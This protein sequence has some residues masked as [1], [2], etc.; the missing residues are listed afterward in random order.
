MAKMAYDLSPQEQ[1]AAI[2]LHKQNAFIDFGD[3]QMFCRPE[4]KKNINLAVLA[5]G[6]DYFQVMGVMGSTNV[7]WPPAL[8]EVFR[9]FSV[10]LASI[11]V[12]AP[13]CL[14]PSFTFATQFY[15]TQL[16]PLAAGGQLLAIHVGYTAY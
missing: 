7:P 4:W 10:F 6:I 1:R 9:V 12:I 16:L 5:V 13:Q 14:I 8:Q 3:A 2:D 11:E 15:M